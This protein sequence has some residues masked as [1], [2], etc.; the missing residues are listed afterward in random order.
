MSRLRSL[1]ALREEENDASMASSP[2]TLGDDDGSVDTSNTGDTPNTSGSRNSRS[3]EQQHH[4]RDK[5]NILQT[6]AEVVSD[7]ETDFPAGP[8]R[9][10]GTPSR[11]QTRGYPPEDPMAIMVSPEMSTTQRTQVNGDGS[12]VSDS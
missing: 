3:R 11:R 5:T 4:P 7:L 1:Q 2:N 12:D 6:A 8:G 10:R 9:V